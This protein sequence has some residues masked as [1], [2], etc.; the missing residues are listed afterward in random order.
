MN[1]IDTHSH[2][3]E[4]KFDTDREEVYARMRERKVTTIVVGTD[5]ETSKKAVEYAR[6]EATRDIVVGA[7]IGVHPTDTNEKFDSMV[8]EQLLC[9]EVVAIGECGFDYFSTPRD[10]VYI[11]Q[12][13]VF[14][15]QIRFAAEH[16]LPLM[17]HVRPS[18]GNSDAYRDA[19]EVLDIYQKEYGD[20][21]RGTIH[22]FTSTREIAR[23]YVMRGFTVSFPGVITFAQELHEV[24]RDVPLDM[25]LAETDAPYATP[26]PH[27]GERNEPVFVIDT[28]KAIAEIRGETFEVVAEQLYKNA[29]TVF[30]SRK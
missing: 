12:R 28:M 13:E 11:R 8:Y 22:F 16:D 2:L 10:D 25:M 26:V 21:V 30:L 27:R 24:V 6:D 3:Y 19:L 14:E 7:T 5:L 23:E 9:K 4:T 17:L 29:Q 18:K 20:T 15:E 1:Y